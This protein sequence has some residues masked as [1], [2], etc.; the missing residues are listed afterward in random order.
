MWEKEGTQLQFFLAILYHRMGMKQGEKT[1]K[2]NYKLHSLEA[3]Q[4]T[5]SNY[6][7]VEFL[8]FSYTLLLLKSNLLQFLLSS[9]LCLLF[10]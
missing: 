9:V 5:W 7:T 3:H 6:R 10:N 4:K 2:K 1:S 8:H